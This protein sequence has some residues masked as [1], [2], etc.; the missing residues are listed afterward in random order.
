MKIFKRIMNH[1][2]LRKKAPVKCHS[3]YA[4]MPNGSMQ[5]DSLSLLLFHQLMNAYENPYTDGADKEDVISAIA[6][7]YQNECNLAW[8]NFLAE[9][10]DDVE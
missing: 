7:N 2:D 1:F 10:D 9:V 5:K 4:L 3:V 8:T 6:A